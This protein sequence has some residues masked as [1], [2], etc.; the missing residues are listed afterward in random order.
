MLYHYLCFTHYALIIPN[1]TVTVDTLLLTCHSWTAGWLSVLAF[2]DYL[3]VFWWLLRLPLA[4]ALHRRASRALTML[5]IV[6]AL[7]LFASTST[8]FSSPFSKDV[9]FVRETAFPVY[10]L[11]LSVF[12]TDPYVKR[13]FHPY[14]RRLNLTKPIRYS[15]AYYEALLFNEGT[16]HDSETEH[17][18]DPISS[19]SWHAVSPDTWHDSLCYHWFDTKT[20]VEV[21]DPQPVKWFETSEGATHDARHLQRLCT[22][23]FSLIRQRGLST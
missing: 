21:V 3:W 9:R 4:P 19:L 14:R 1:L 8:V 20:E 7:W 12:R 18:Y 6:V 13:T 10:P 23:F 22:G 5:R 15:D 11:G 17:W 16:W 2:F